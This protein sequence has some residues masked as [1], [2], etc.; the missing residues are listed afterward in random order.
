MGIRKFSY[1]IKFVDCLLPYGPK[2]QWSNSQ[3]ANLIGFKQG[4]FWNPYMCTFHLA[5]FESVC[6]FMRVRPYQGRTLR[7]IKIWTTALWAMSTTNWNLALYSHTCFARTKVR[8]ISICCRNCSQGSC[9]YFDLPLVQK[10]TAEISE[11][12]NLVELWSMP[13]K[14]HSK[15]TSLCETNYGKIAEIRRKSAVSISVVFLS[16]KC[17][18]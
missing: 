6:Q 15:M 18:I 10:K 2:A 9:S 16:S 13:F 3:K 12:A 8:K 14:M 1:L 4:M 5:C 7:D 17:P 11:V